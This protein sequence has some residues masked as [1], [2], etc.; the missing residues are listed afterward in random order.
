MTLTVVVGLA[1]S[2][3]SNTCSPLGKRYSLMPST[4]VTFCPAT[5]DTAARDRLATSGEA[6]AKGTQAEAI[7]RGSN[8]KVKRLGLVM[9]SIS[10]NKACHECQTCV[11]QVSTA[12][13]DC[14]CRGARKGS[15]LV[16]IPP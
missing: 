3:T 10:V 12:C 5:F 8:A 7:R 9:K 14:E 6:C 11:A 1:S 16:F 13:R 15:P 4:L 2:G